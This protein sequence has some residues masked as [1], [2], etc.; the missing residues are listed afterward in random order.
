[1]PV[2]EGKFYRWDEPTLSWVEVTQ[3]V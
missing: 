3:G 2:V 1:M